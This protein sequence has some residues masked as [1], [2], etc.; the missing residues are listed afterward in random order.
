MSDAAGLGQAAFFSRRVIDG[1]R[2]R[3]VERTADRINE[4]DSGWRFY[5]GDEPEAY[6]D[7]A[8]NCV[9]QHLAHATDRWPELKTVI[10]DTAAASAWQWDGS[11]A[12]YR[13]FDD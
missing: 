13:P 11:S 6:L 1:E 9:L 4:H 7:R 2:P 10:A 8:E 12:Q 5:V 3:Y